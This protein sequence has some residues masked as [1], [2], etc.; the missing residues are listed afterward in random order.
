MV[1]LDTIIALPS[2]TY[3]AD[4]DTHEYHEGIKSSS[5][6]YLRMLKL[7]ILRVIGTECYS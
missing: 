7:C 4:L 2:I 1:E 5:T 3:I 6:T